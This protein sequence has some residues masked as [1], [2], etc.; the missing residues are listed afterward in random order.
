MPWLLQV[1][2]KFGRSS[3]TPSPS[4]HALCSAL[5]D[6]LSGTLWQHCL[7]INTATQQVNRTLSRAA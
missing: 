5:T 3:E 7:L 4:H 2:F 6:T 1:T